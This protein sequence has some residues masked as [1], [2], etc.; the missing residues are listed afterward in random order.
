MKEMAYLKLVYPSGWEKIRELLASTKIFIPDYSP[1][2]PQSL[3]DLTDLN[4]GSAMILDSTPFDPP[5]IPIFLERGVFDLGLVGQN[6]ISERSADVVEVTTFSLLFDSFDPV[7][8]VLAASEESGFQS[9]ADLPSG[10]LIATGYP[11]MARKYLAEKGRGDIQVIETFGGSGNGDE[12]GA[13]YLLKAGIVSAVIRLTEDNLPIF[14]RKL[15]VIDI[16]AEQK[17]TLAVN[18][19]AFLDRRK[20]PA[21]RRFGRMIRDCFRLMLLSEGRK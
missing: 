4:L 16:I 8:L 9:L 10:A 21:I 5:D 3:L 14:R 19:Q 2:G 18:R 12:N 15:L 17:M 20:G 11:N 1:V 6:W 13:S 7:S